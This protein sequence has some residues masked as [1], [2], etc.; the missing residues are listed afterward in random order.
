[1]EKLHTCSN[2][3]FRP[4]GEL[5]R[6][7]IATIL[8]NYTKFKKVPIANQADLSNFKDVASVNN[9]ML[10]AMKW[11]VGNKIISG[12]SGG[13]MLDPKGMASRIEVAAMV[14]NY[15]KNIAK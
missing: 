5:T 9:S 11:A 15:C 1:M 4:K 8:M 3:E 10:A 14:M 7:Q 13:T 2:G 12:K 6:E